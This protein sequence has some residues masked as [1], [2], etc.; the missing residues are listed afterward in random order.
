MISDLIFDLDGTLVDSCAICVNILSDMLTERGSDHVID[1]IG[2]RA[3]MSRGGEQMVAALLGSA[4]RDPKADLA[5]F[6]ARYQETTTPADALFPGVA[7]GLAQ[8]HGDG[9]RLS[10][11]SNKPQVLCEQVL[12]DTALADLF[13]VVVG[14]QAGLRAKPEPDLLD[15]TLKALDTHPRHAIY[16]GDSELDH[17]VAHAFDIPFV[18]MTYGYA[19]GGELPIGIQRFDCFATMS[20]SLSSQLS[21]RNAA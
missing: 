1:R 16:I 9:F 7:A 11:C 14:G 15:A 21:S 10:I 20:K 4:C 12:A 8:L 13:S 3:Y 17:A 6:R 5:E 19:E 2:A 18:F